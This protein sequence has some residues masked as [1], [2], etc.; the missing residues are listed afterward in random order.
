MSLASPVHHPLHPQTQT[1]FFFLIG[2][3]G[4]IALLHDLVLILLIR[5]NFSYSRDLRATRPENIL[6]HF[7][8][9]WRFV[10]IT[11]SKCPMT[12]MPDYFLQDTEFTRQIISLRCLTSIICIALRQNINSAFHS[13]PNARLTVKRDTG[14]YARRKFSIEFPFDVYTILRPSSVTVLIDNTVMLLRSIQTTYSAY[15]M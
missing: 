5:M 11:L 9:H 6:E 13:N 15:N 4:H 3:Y 12:L 14:T 2:L 8:W 1:Q 7:D 10:F